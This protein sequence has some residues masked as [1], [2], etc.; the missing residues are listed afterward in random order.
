MEV[1]VGFAGAAALSCVN[2]LPHFEQNLAPAR[3]VAPQEAQRTGRAA[4]HVSQN[5]LSSG[6]SEWQLG[7]SMSALFIRR[8]AGLRNQS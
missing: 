7:H 8:A 6:I 4:P 2:A 5:L 3:L 1:V